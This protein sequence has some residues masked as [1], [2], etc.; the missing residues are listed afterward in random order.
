MRG[1]WI[2]NYGGTN[3]GTAVVDIDDMGDHFEGRAF[4]YDDRQDLPST[5]AA[6]RT[7]DKARKFQRKRLLTAAAI[8][9]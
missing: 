1:Q 8:F 3:T 7:A 2:G 6:I 4:V 9:S 5:Y